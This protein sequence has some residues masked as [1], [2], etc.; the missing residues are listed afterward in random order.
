M[1]AEVMSNPTRGTTTITAEHDVKQSHVTMAWTLSYDRPNIHTALEF[2][3]GDYR[4]RVEENMSSYLT[5][6]AESLE[7]RKRVTNYRITG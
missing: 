5:G 7:V 1:I 2:L 3:P 4:P 6:V